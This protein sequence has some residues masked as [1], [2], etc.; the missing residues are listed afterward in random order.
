MDRLPRA[1]ALMAALVAGLAGLPSSAEEASF[2]TGVR[3]ILQKRC[4]A[5]HQGPNAQNGLSLDTV[6]GLLRGGESGPAVVPGDPGASLLLA[7]AGGRNP[8]MPPAGD[9]LTPEEIAILTSWIK[10]GA[11]EDPLGAVTGPEATWWSLRPFEESPEPVNSTPWERSRIDGYLSA[12]MQEKGLGPSPAASPRT[13]IRRL[14][15]GLTGLPPDPGDVEAFARDGSPAAYERLVDRLLA[16][17]AYG[18]RWGRHWLDVARFGESNGYEQNHLRETAWPYRDWVI[19]ALNEDK[20]FNRMIV[21]QLAGDQLAPNDPRTNAATGFLVAGPHDTVGIRNPEGEAQKR[22]NHLD[23]MVMGTASAFLGLT[24]H[25]ARCHDHKFDPIATEDYYRMQ[26]AF[27]GVWHGQRTWDDPS[28]VEAFKAA[29][30]PLT[31]EIEECKRGLEDLRSGAAERVEARRESIL[32]RYRP[33]VDPA[34]TEERFDP[35]KAR[36]VRM[37]IS[38]ST[39]GVRQVDLDEFSVWSDGRRNRNVALG[40]IASASSTRVDSASP[41]T[42]SAANLVDGKYDRRWI[43]SGRLPAWVQVELPRP[44]VISRVSW[45]SDRIGGFGGRYDRP[46]PEEYRIEVSTDGRSWKAVAD[47]QQRLPYSG[48]DRELLLLHEVFTPEE[49]NGWSDFETRRREA[50]KQLQRLNRPQAA[51]L[52][53]FIQPDAPSFVMVRG[54]P[55]SK[56]DQ[57]SPGSLSTLGHLLQPY[58]LAPDAPESERRLAL[59]QWIA[60]D[61]NALTARVIVNRVWMYHFGKPFVRTPSDF[62]INGGEPSHP[63]LLDWLAQRLV[64]THRWRLKPLH[65]DIVLSAA[66][67]QSG[68]FRADAAEIDSDGAFLWR[69]PPRRLSAE[70]LRDAILATSGDLNRRMGGPGFRLYRYTVDNVATY[71]PL[72]QFGRDTHRRSVYHQHARSVKPDLLGEFDCP[73]TSLPSPKRISTTSPLQALSLL[74][75]RFV[76]DQAAAFAARVDAEQAET[77]TVASRVTHAWRLALGRIP[78]D[79]E[80]R[81]AVDFV[82]KE[83]LTSLGRALLNANEFLY[84]F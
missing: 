77:E 74:N 15:F 5:C 7:K 67:R 52:G 31:A 68:L 34:G 47:S 43:S 14:A 19:R 40:S 27:N 51:F 84:V 30:G 78:T 64:H 24:V 23:D 65:R 44:E 21:E 3:P 45:S 26:S 6:A 10:A 61:D 29:S 35:I 20:P 46:Q 38:R 70:E 60:S 79:M 59:A 63:R 42:Y 17:P 80:L 56:G 75:N 66:Y 53:E 41:D 81:V 62:G 28:Q 13:L 33:S 32:A 25:C 48:D 83:G 16:S 22:A 49:R 73:D 39:K 8:V 18:E 11:P 1:L 71:Y 72:Q 82:R 12:A 55:M 36:F 37:T 69:F 2:A 54:N 58:Q 9:P 4:T 50:D 57:V 76:L